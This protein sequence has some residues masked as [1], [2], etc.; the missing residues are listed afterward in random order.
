MPPQIPNASSPKKRVASETPGVGIMAP[1]P[2][3]NFLTN[4]QKGCAT[5]SAE[6]RQNQEFDSE[7][8]RLQAELDS[9]SKNVASAASS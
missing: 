7:N 8:A 4:S 5:G 9:F 6:K 2:K 1:T 3:R